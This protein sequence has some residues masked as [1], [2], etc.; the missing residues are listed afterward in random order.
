MLGFVI[1]RVLQAAVVMLVIS[2]LV[3][4]GVYAVGNPIDVLISPDATQ[5]IR[6]QTIKAYGLDQPLWKQYLDFLGRLLQGDFGRSF[7]Y[8]MPVLQLIFS[9]LPATIELISL[10]TLGWPMAELV[11]VAPLNL[12]ALEALAAARHLDADVYLAAADENPPLRAA[13]RTFGVTIQTIDD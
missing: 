11:H 3:F 7:V 9:R 5:I 4:T 6:E 2:A 1:Q 10:R 13:A 12:L 8:N